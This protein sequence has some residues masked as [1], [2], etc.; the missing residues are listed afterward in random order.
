ME[1]RRRPL[2]DPRRASRS[3]ALE[4]EAG[5]LA[6]P[7]GVGDAVVA[8]LVLEHPPDRV[9]RQVGAELDVARHREVRH[10]LDATTGTAPPR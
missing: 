7:G 5:R 10:L 4:R 3:A 6:V 9:A 2:G 1:G 8:Q